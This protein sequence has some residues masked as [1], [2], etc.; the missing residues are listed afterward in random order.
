MEPLEK[1]AAIDNEIEAICLKGE[2][3]QR[4]IPHLIQ[5]YH[6]SAY[7]G[8][9]QFHGGWG[10]VEAPADYSRE[11]LQILDDLRCRSS[12]RIEETS[13]DEKMPTQVDRP[14]F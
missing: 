10:H 7:D 12:T 13:L 5:S 2:L 9:F 6:D 1:I 14:S 8:L 4:G 11:I 3:E